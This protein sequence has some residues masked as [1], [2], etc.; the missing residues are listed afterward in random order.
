MKN[1]IQPV[2]YACLAVSLAVAG[3]CNSSSSSAPVTVASYSYS[4]TSSKGDYAEWTITGGALDATWNVEDDTG[5]IEYTLTLTATCG[6][7]DTYGVHTCTITDSSCTGGTLACPA[8]ISGDFEMMDVPGVALFVNTGSELHVGF[9][10]DATAC[11]HDVSGDYTMIRTGLGLKEN[12]GVYRSDTN[13]VNIIHAD[14]GFDTPDT[15]M[16]QTVAYRTGGGTGTGM[17]T[18]I[19]AGC[20]DG[21]RTRTAGTD[22]IR[23]M[24]TASGLFVMDFPAGQ[25]GVVSFKIANAATLADFANTSFGGISFPDDGPSTLVKADFGVVVG[26]HIDITATVGSAT[27]NLA[28]ETL[29]ASAAVT[30]PTYPDFT[31]VPTGYL[32][33]TLSGASDYPNPAAIPGMFKLDN[34]SDP[35]RVILAAMKYNSKV[36]CVGMVYNYRTTGDINPS[37]GTFFVADGLYNAGNFI[38]F[39]K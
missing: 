4:T 38:L 13:F 12:F 6:D 11:G 1:Y 24:M 20:A 17:D 29:A 8:D 22:T 32:N 15:N 23:S 7:P 37:T 30:N 36:I 27:Q 18:L 26:D 28:I 19:D 35:G 21:V 2:G 14:F 5:A 34:P 39:E 10:K 3:G 31:T 33:S 9:A 16:T 25:G